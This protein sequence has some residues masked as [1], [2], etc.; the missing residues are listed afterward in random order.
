MFRSGLFHDYDSSLKR[1][2]GNRFGFL[3]PCRTGHDQGPYA[4]QGFLRHGAFIIQCINFSICFYIIGKTSDLFASRLI[5]LHRLFAFIPAV[6]VLT[7]TLQGGNLT[8]EYCLPWILLS[9]Y[10]CLKYFR[11]VQE[12]KDFKHPV[13]FSLYNGAAVGVICFIRITS[14]ATIG[15]VLLTVFVVMLAK[16]EIKNLLINLV[17]VIAGLQRQAR[18]PVLS[19]IQKACSKRC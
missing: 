15:A 8:E 16:K 17:M 11:Q 7:V 9:I 3:Y 13:L 14:A 6:L 4:L 1:Q 5:W 2:V 19:F 18:S 10:F 12:K